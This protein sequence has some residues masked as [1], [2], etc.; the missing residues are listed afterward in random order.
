MPSATKPSDW[1]LPALWSAMGAV[2][3]GAL[4]ARS[5]GPLA[6]V[7]VGAGVFVLGML[8]GLR[9]PMRRARAA[10]GDFPEA[11]RAW[12]EAHVPLY[13]RGSD[14][15]RALF[16]A[17]VLV[18]LDGWSI[19]GVDGV[20]MTDE[21]R[22]MVAS[23]A[24]VLLWGRPEWD[25]PAGRSMLLYPGTFDDEFGTE[26]AG[27]FDG[28]AHAQGPVLFSAPAVR[29][30]WA[31]QNGYNVVLHELAHVFDFGPDG[32]DGAPSFLDA[33]SADAW[34]DLV[35][36][37]MRRAARGDGVLRAYAATN[38]AEL[39]A[40]STEVFFERPARLRQHHPELFEALRAV[41]NVTPPDEAPAQPSGESLMS[42]RWDST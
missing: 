20:E 17:R 16:E 31:R 11:W 34:Q 40:V 33:R 22:L 12:A 21:L 10:S 38:P 5:A 25:V 27:S 19:E 41:Y 23:G 28:M 6:G 18:A 3:A 30:G 32:A 35:H 36:R 29:S 2:L 14:E 39:F 9:G 1:L 26:D 37:E 8:L 13:A 7:L 24:G 15:E 42:R 4:V